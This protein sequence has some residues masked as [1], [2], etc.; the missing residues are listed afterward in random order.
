MEACGSRSKNKGREKKSFNKKWLEIGQKIEFEHTC[1]PEKATRI[2]M[3]HLTE[4]P[5]YYKELVKM[6]KKLEDKMK[7]GKTKPRKIKKPKKK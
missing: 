7:K 4:S 1:D 3:D 2:A 5:D 6:E